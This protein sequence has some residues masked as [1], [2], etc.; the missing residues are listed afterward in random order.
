MRVLAIDHGDRRLGLAVSDP[1]GLTA[2]SLGFYELQDEERDLA[3]FR[4]LAD[5][6]KIAEVVVGLPLRMDGTEGTRA[7]KTRRFARLLSERLELRIVFWDERLTTRQALGIL[8]EGNI[9]GQKRKMRKDQVAACLILSA[10][11]E[12]KRP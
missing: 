12:S 11:L 8:R 10:Y 7:E 6:Y 9:R 5:E 4:R 1:L 3:Y 2:Q